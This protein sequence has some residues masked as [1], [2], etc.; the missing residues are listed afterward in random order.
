L[1]PPQHLKD[2]LLINGR[3]NLALKN[4]ICS[5]LNQPLPT[6]NPLAAAQLAA[7]V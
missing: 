1:H 7:V 2:Q 6:I 4:L 3:N 5:Q